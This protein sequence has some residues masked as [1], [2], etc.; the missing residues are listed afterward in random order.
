MVAC[1][2]L[3]VYLLYLP[4]SFA[5][6]IQSCCS[7]SCPTFFSRYN[8][9][10][11]MLVVKFSGSLVCSFLTF[12]S[13][14]SV[15]LGSVFADNLSELFV[16]LLYLPLSFALSIQSCC[17]VSCPTFFSRYNLI[18]LMLVVKFS[19]SLV[20][21]FLTFCSCV[22]VFLGFVFADNLS[23]LCVYLLYLAVFFLF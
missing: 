20:C 6:L 10:A 1:S 14:V 21:S 8:L 9:I 19:G 18:A 13:C 12:R 7:V 23:E 4:L 15:F 16:Y 22:S 17:S 5:I 2:E 11:L 3:C